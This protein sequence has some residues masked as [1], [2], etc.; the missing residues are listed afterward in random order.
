MYGGQKEKGRRQ[1]PVMVLKKPAQR[2]AAKSET[3]AAAGR[4][5]RDAGRVRGYFSESPPKREAAELEEEVT[6]CIFFLF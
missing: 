6:V 5:R 2:N 3:A 4:R 1:E